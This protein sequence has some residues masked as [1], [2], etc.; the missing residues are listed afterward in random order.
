MD[1]A[2][3]DPELARLRE[4]ARRS[5]PGARWFE[6]WEQQKNDL[7]KEGHQWTDAQKIKEEKEYLQLVERGGW[8]DDLQQHRE[9]QLEAMLKAMDEDARANLVLEAWNNR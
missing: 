4:E 6:Q 3:A 2:Y 8:V 5:D 1:E 7:Q 9:V